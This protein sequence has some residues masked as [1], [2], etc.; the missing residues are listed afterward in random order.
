MKKWIFAVPAAPVAAFGLC[1]LA[2]FLQAEYF[3]AVEEPQTKKPKIAFIGDSITYGTGTLLTRKKD[4][5]PV[6]V[7]EQLPEYEVLNYGFND[8]TLQKEGDLPYTKEKMYPATLACKADV[9]VIMLGTNDTKKKNWDPERYESEYKDFVKQYVDIAGAENVYVMQ[10][11]RC[12]PVFGMKDALYGIRCAE[13]DKLPGIAR[14]VANEL[15]CKTIDLY[16]LTKDHPEW[17]IDG[18]H[19]TAKGNK[20]IAAAIVQNLK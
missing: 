2:A 14:R 10:Q 12:F 18:V 7:Q 9:Y 3:P 11:S 16:T 4:A 6:F 15:G 17:F 20:A 13:V 19:P 8:R 5:F 1:Y